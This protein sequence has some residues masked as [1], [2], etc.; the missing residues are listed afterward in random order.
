[1]GLTIACVF[2]DLGVRSHCLDRS[3]AAYNGRVTLQYLPIDNT[4]HAFASAG[5]AL[6]HAVRLAQHE[7][8]VLVHQDVYLHSIDRLASAAA[9]LDDPQW[10]VLGASGVTADRRWVG[11]LRDRVILIGDPASTPVE[12]DSLDEVLFMARREDLL[13]EP[14]SEHPDLAWHAY[15]VEYSLRMRGAGRRAGA[16]DTAITHNSL[17]ANLARLHEAHRHVGMRYAGHRPIHTTCGTVTA[18]G[19]GWADVPVVR[20][21]RWR[22]TWLRQSRKAAR[23]RASLGVP[24]VLA[25]IAHEV[26]FLAFSTGSPLHLVN[27]DSAGGFDG[28]AAAPVQ[29]ER[30]GRP[31]LMSSVSGRSGDELAEVLGGLAAADHVLLTGLA[32]DDLD[33]LRSCFNSGDWLAGVQ[34][35]EAWMIGGPNASHPPAVWSRPQARPLGAGRSPAQT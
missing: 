9:A 6:N 31:I 22:R 23:V 19:R 24:V 18:R 14:L 7:V 33:R 2:N 32:I 10:G 5:A 16:V 34:W 30:R 21:H 26:D 29:L 13:A 11:R 27:L 12:V 17:T 8:V 25:D 1:M 3:L 15:A 20:N 4:T 28:A 35:D